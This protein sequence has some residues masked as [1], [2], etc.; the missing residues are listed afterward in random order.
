M[1]LRQKKILIDDD[2]IKKLS[3]E[4]KQSFILTKILVSRGYDTLEKL[5]KFL[6]PCLSD[7]HDPFLLN[8]MGVL[9]EKIKHAIQ[10]KQKVLIFGDYD[11]DGISATAI[12]Y[13]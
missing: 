5:N 2:E 11:V 8:N 3:D 4:I 7:L 10:A 13:R 12:L 6:N 9:V 1:I